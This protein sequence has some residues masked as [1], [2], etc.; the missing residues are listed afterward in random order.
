MN[1]SIECELAS[2]GLVLSQTGGDLLKPVPKGGGD[3]AA[4][5]AAINWLSSPQ[6]SA[7][8]AINR[9]LPELPALAVVQDTH[10]STNPSLEILGFGISGRGDAVLRSAIATEG[11]TLA[12]IHEQRHFNVD[13]TRFKRMLQQFVDA[14]WTGERAAIDVR[15]GEADEVAEFVFDV[16]RGIPRSVKMR[17]LAFSV[18]ASAEMGAPVES[19]LRMEVGI[20]VLGTQGSWH[21][22]A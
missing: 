6:D 16:E 11:G 12:H 2:T 9:L 4:I 17:R 19:R 13:V 18:T 8:W 22:E 5:A 3:S 7:A 10:W 1:V 20:E 14:Q 15:S 21:V